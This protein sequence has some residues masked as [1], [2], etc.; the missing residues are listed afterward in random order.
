MKRRTFIQ[1]AS[2]IASAAAFTPTKIFRSSQIMT[3]LGPIKPS[4]LGTTL[5]HEHVMADFIGAK[6]TGPHRYKVDEVVAKALPYLLDLKKAGCKT[7][8]DCTPVYLGRDARVLKKLSQ[9]TGM[10]IL[11]T[12][13]YYGA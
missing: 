8:V 11:T 6:E 10:N 1:K 12:T 3:V 5:V 2:L 7:F 4:D 9:E 13:G